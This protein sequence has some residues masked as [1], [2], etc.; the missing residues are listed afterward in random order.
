MSDYSVR[1]GAFANDLNAAVRANPLP[2]ALIGMGLVWL[3]AGGRPGVTAGVA[4]ALGGVSKAAAQTGDAARK[5]GQ[6]VG[7]TVASA[8]DAVRDGGATVAQKAA[9]IASSVSDSSSQA[10]RSVPAFDGQLFATA[11]SSLADLMKKQPLLLGAIGVAIGAG[12]A[13]SLRPTAIEVD[14][15]GEASANFKEKAGQLVS[16]ATERAGAVVDGVATTVAQE[17]RA[18]GLTKEDLSGAASEAGR[19]V[20]RVIGRT[21][22]RF[23]ASVN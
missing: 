6:S 7:E 13:A 2:A 19:K 3:F 11:Q 8:R 22:E 20:E 9:D 21:T 18:Q 10:V 14:L 1:A 5:L 23:R 15:L 17:A 4:N 12:V 16:A